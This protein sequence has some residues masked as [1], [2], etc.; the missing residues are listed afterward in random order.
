MEPISLGKLPILDWCQIW[1]A[2]SLS[3]GLSGSVL[4]LRYVMLM[5]VTIYFNNRNHTDIGLELVLV[6][7]L[8]LCF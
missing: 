7:V 6:L 4:I 5:N 1:T 3:R 8:L 2:S